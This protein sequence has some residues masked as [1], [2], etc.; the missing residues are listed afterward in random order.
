[1]HKTPALLKRWIAATGGNVP[2][3]SS[4]S[5]ISMELG[6]QLQQVDPELFQIVSGAE[7][8]AT[9]ELAVMDGS[10]PDVAIP[11][12]DREAAANR[13]EAERLIAE[14]AFPQLGYYT[15]EGS[16]VEGREGNFT[17]QMLVKDLAP[18]LYERHAALVSAAKAQQHSDPNALTTEGANF[19]QA[20]LASRN[21]VEAA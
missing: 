5:S 4:A 11:Q 10:L 13:A 1:V 16:Y 17:N 2:Y 3:P 14:G 8:P 21:A 9:L 12:A 20:R 7:I 18:D 19:V 6:F 15:P